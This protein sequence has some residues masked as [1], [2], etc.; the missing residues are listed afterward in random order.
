MQ[1][2]TLYYR[3]KGESAYVILAMSK[4]GDTYTAAIPAS[5]VTT[6]GV[7]YY[8]SATDG[9]NAATAPAA[10]PTTAPFQI[11]VTERAGAASQLWLWIIVAIVIIAIIALVAMMARKKPGA[12]ETVPPPEEQQ[13]P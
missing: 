3:K 6:A 7:Q 10:D 13:V 8:I 9:A 12:P 2:A 5:A 11:A 1:S 4:S